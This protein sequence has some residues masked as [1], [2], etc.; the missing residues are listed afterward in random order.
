MESRKDDMQAVMDEV[1]AMGLWWLQSCTS[2]PPMG[3]VAFAASTAQHDCKVVRVRSTCAGRGR[4]GLATGDPGL[5][6]SAVAEN[7]TD[8]S[9]TRHKPERANRSAHNG[10][11]PH[12]EKSLSVGKRGFLASTC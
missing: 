3:F 9:L 11:V 8:S 7:T 6:P 12:C 2:N 5:I 4:I 1:G 10:S